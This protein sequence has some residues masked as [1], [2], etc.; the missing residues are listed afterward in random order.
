MP[1]IDLQMT[2]EDFNLILLA[3]K[4]TNAMTIGDL[5][6]FIPIANTYGFDRYVY[7]TELSMRF[8]DFFLFI[9]FTIYGAIV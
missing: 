1:P 8:A 9:I 3:Q 6:S 5:Y 2:L 7:Q 4:G